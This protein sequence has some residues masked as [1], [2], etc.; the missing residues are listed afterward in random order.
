MIG[1]NIWST[2]KATGKYSIHGGIDQ[3]F[4]N[5]MHDI[6]GLVTGFGRGLGVFGDGKLD[7]KNTSML[8]AF[9][10]TLGWGVGKIGAT[11]A[12][13]VI[14]AGQKAVTNT[15]ESLVRWGSA[16]G[17]LGRGLGKTF[18]KE[19]SENAEYSLFGYE[20]R[21]L[22][23]HAIG[24]GAVGYGIVKGADAEDF[25][26]GLRTAVNGMMDTEG[27]ATVPGSVNQTYTPL[28]ERGR[29]KKINNF[30]ADGNLTLALHNRR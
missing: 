24:L 11:V 4:Q 18:F 17:K 28:Y 15:P 12:K 30:N 20:A 23:P 5:T 22:T 3:V 27:V 29:G 19:A 8:G 21:M 14:A 26:M 13:P 6:G 16:T 1:H 10:R 7:L 9:T 2:V 25:N